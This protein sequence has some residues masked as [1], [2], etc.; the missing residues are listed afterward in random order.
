MSVNTLENVGRPHAKKW[1]KGKLSMI[2]CA[3]PTF[4]IDWGVVHQSFDHVCH[5]EKLCCMSG[6]WGECCRSSTR[7]VFLSPLVL[8]SVIFASR[9]GSPF[10]LF[11]KRNIFLIGANIVQPSGI[12]FTV[13][14]GII[15]M[16]HSGRE[17][18]FY[19]PGV[20]F[21]RSCHPT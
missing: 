8:I 4:I 10:L 6:I 3:G 16:Q 18:L 15:G 17:L 14:D 19:A 2:V 12:L 9:I 7:R 20:G 5:A 13:C 1:K 11:P 21:S